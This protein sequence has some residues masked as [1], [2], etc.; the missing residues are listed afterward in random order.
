MSY[1]E[2]H[3]NRLR[4]K[5]LRIINKCKKF[6]LEPLVSARSDNGLLVSC[7]ALNVSIPFFDKVRFNASKTII[8]NTSYKKK[9][10][11]SLVNRMA[12]RLAAALFQL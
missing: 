1:D 12:T 9:N 2:N 8:K 7:L 4:L 3:I 6:L 11:P 10:G 5:A